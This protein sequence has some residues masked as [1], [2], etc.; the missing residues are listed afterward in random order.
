M[1]SEIYN[2]SVKDIEGNIFTIDKY[3]GKVLL[4]VNTASR[5]GFTTQYKGLQTLYDKYNK[6]GFEILG[7]PCNQFASQEPED[8]NKIKEFCELNY[9]I[10]FPMFSKIEVNGKNEHQLY[11]YLKSE[12]SGILGE[13]IKWNFTKFLVSK[14]GKVVKRFAPITKPEDIEKFIISELNSVKE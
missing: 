12:A 3:S 8:E 5:C 13:D 6:L 7:F 2:I 10:T 9:N 4:I 11:T 1:K 14:E